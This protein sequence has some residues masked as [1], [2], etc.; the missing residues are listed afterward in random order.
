MSVAILAF[1]RA[2][3]NPGL[4]AVHAV[5]QRAEARPRAGCLTCAS[6]IWLKLHILPALLER[7]LPCG[8]QAQ[9][10]EYLDNPDNRHRVNI[11]CAEELRRSVAREHNVPLEELAW[12]RGA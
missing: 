2:F 9:F 11:E 5:P 10:T 6:R 8:E 1:V 3:P 12:A 7:C 4:N